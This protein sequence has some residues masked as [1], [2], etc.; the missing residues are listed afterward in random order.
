MPHKPG[1]DQQAP[2]VPVWLPDKA[3]ENEAI[4]PVRE[5]MRDQAEEEYRRLLYVGL[6]RAAD[7]LVVCG[8][9]GVREV[10]TP[11]WHSLASAGLERAASESGYT[12]SDGVHE[13]VTEPFEARRFRRIRTESS[14]ARQANQAE[15]KTTPAVSGSALVIPTEPLPP[16]ARLP[17]PLAPSGVSAVLEDSGE[18]ASRSPFAENQTGSTATLERGSMIHRLLQVLPAVPSA[19]RQTVLARY[20]AR[21][22]P[23]EQEASVKTIETQV[24]GVLRDARFA[25]IFDAPGEAEVSVMGTLRIKGEERAVSGRIDRIA[26]D[27]DRVLIV[28]Y[29]TGLAPKPDEEPPASHVSQLAIYR[30]LLAPLYP[31]RRIDAALVYVSGPF[32]IEI[33]GSALDQAMARLDR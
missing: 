4:A 32:L 26:L 24:L 20:L 22:L 27:G 10:K 21:A 30:A 23:A 13:A 3:H 12:V 9:R 15:S 1:A 33:P 31:G 17:R 28:D 25:P 16:P 19:E 8:Y 7:R 18:V 6:T 29:K 11:T 2:S 5:K 14:A